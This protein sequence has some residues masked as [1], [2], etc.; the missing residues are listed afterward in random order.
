MC[1]VWLT[2]HC[3]APALR[4]HPLGGLGGRDKESWRVIER[5]RPTGQSGQ[6]AP[7]PW[8]LTLTATYGAYHQRAEGCRN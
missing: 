8:L 1:S 4:R 2:G 3:D 7:L 5:W 6:P